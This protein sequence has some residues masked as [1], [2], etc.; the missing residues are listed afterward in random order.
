MD[1]IGILE[2]LAALFSGKQMNSLTT[3]IRDYRAEN[4]QGKIIN[5]H[6]TVILRATRHQEATE[7]EWQRFEL[8]S[9][10]LRQQTIDSL[11]R[12]GQ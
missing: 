1:P 4:G 7:K 5:W 2:M 10:D 6:Y 3:Q 12:S 9:L 8:N 11:T